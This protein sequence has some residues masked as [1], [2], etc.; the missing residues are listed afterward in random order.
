MS[1]SFKVNPKNL[2]LERE[3]YPRRQRR[4]SARKGRIGPTE[5]ALA[6]AAIEEQLRE[7]DVQQDD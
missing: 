6:L 1:K 4:N 5:G 2:E 3:D 7:L